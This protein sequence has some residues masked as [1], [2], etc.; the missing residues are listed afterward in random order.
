MRPGAAVEDF[1]APLFIAWQLTNSC[2]GRCPTCCE[3]SGPNHGWPDELTR[4]E[5]LRV[6]R[7]IAGA[8]IPYAAFGGGEPLGVPHVWEIFDTL[9]AAGTSIKIE[10]DGRYVDAAAAARMARL[11]VDNAQISVDGARAGTHERLRPGSASFDQ[12]TGALRHLSA[13]G[14]PAEL[15]FT[16]TRH[17][18]AEMAD[19][20]DL[21]V[22]LGCSA[23][24]TGPL[25]R[26]GRAAADW[27]TLAP[28]PDAW[29]E[30]TT[31]LRARAAG[32][33]DAPTRLSIYPHD[34]EREIADRLASP[35]AM[36]LI[37][38]NGRVKLLNALPFA[39]GDLRRQTLLQA[40]SR[41]QQAWRS[42][43]VADFIHRCRGAPE[44]LRHANETWPVG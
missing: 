36:M 11:R 23:F 22:E 6:A 18:L 7:E 27:Q 32:R 4:D 14:V 35:Q 29:A 12:A 8:G 31:D 19:A 21:A 2:A 13:H 34:I 43:E 15:V 26:L 28:D 42:A 25:M 39:P 17:N 16:P 20:F 41:Y 10:T 38:P 44:L 40:W 37:V 33:R 30:A 9:S 3:D 1:R 5:A 24:V